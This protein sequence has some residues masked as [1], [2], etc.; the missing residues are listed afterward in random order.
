MRLHY[1]R[2]WNVQELEEHD[3]P[4]SKTR[5]PG[6]TLNNF[7]CNEVEEY[8]GKGGGREYNGKGGG[9]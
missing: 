2:E 1:S 6:N 5:R 4:G 9:K 3:S 7:Y 8:E